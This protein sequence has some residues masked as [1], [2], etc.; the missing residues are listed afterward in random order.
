MLPSG[1]S[2]KILL[3]TRNYENVTFKGFVVGTNWENDGEIADVITVHRATR[4]K[5]ICC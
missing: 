3:P 4:L 5:S 2:R 1:A